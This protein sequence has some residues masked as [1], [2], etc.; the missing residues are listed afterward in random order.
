MTSFFAH[1]PAI[2]HQIIG[3]FG[4][5]QSGQNSILKRETIHLLREIERENINSR[6]N[7]LFSIYLLFFSLS[8]PFFP[9]LSVSRVDLPGRQSPVFGESAGAMSVC[10]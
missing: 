3:T 5:N 1:S 7:A 10:W 6:M 9:L 4:G 8:L 2:T